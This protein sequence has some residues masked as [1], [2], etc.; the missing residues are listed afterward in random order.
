MGQLIKNKK[1]FT[2][3]EFFKNFVGVEKN[4]QKTLTGF[5]LIELL[6]VIAIIGLLATIVMVSVN[7]ARSKARDVK[8]AADIKQ[9]ALALEIYYD[10]NG[11]YPTAA[12]WYGGTGNCWGTVTDNWVP[13][14]VS[15]YISKLPLD[16]KPTA[17]SSVYLYA[18][19]GANYKIIAHV[20]ENCENSTYRGIKDPARDGGSD[21]SIVD[22]NSC[23]AWSIYTPGTAASW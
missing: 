1:G 15:T 9:V 4:N 22:G 5:T 23:W 3:L 7:S 6:V 19:G 17:C 12:A 11:S 21:P 8:R 14:L 10:T 2:P 16:P 13:G 20:P 18:G